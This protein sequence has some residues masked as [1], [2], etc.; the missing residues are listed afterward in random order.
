MYFPAVRG[1]IRD[2]LRNEVRIPYIDIQPTSL[3]QAM[4]RVR[5]AHAIDALVLD[6]PHVFDNVLL[7]FT[8]HDRGRN[9]RSA[10]FN[11]ECWLLLLDF[12]RDYMSE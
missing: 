12:P 5:D 8:K 2:F 7:T 9:W 10:G 1:V 4:V 3:G 11:H 6:S